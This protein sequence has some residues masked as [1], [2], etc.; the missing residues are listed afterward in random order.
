[1]APVDKLDLI[2]IALGNFL[3]QNVSRP[4]TYKAQ[5]QHLRR[6]VGSLQTVCAE[7]LAVIEELSAE[8]ARRLAAMTEMDARIHELESAV[9]ARSGQSPPHVPPTSRMKRWKKASV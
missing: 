7:R 2:M 4:T 6:E 5:I 3:S 8:A 1:V 9:A